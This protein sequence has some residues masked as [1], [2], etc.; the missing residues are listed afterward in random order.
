MLGGFLVGLV[1][2]LPQQRIAVEFFPLLTGWFAG[3]VVGELRFT[4]PVPAKRTVPV[5]AVVQGWLLRVPHVLA[6]I[7]AGVTALVLTLVGTGEPSAQVL[8]WCS[9]ALACAAV[10]AAINRYVLHRVGGD[11]EVDILAASRAIAAH[12][13]GA[14][15]AAGSALVVWCLTHQLT[16]LADHAFDAAAIAAHGI[17][18]LWTIGALVIARLLVTATSPGEPVDSAEDRQP[19]VPVLLVVAVL[20]AVSAGWAGYAYWQDHPPYPARAVQAT[21]TVRFTT[22]S[23]FEQDANAMGLAGLTTTVGAPHRRPFIGRVDHTVPAGADNHDT[24]YVIVIDKRH[25]R[26]AGDLHDNTGGGWS[27][28]LSNLAKRYPWLSSTAPTI[29]AAGY[30]YQGSAVSATADSPDPITFAG[31]LDHAEHLSPADLT[32]VLILTGP[33]TKST[34]P[35]PY[36]A[37]THRQASAHTHG[38]TGRRIARSEAPQWSRPCLTSRAVSPLATCETRRCLAGNSISY[39]DLTTMRRRWRDHRVLQPPYAAAGISRGRR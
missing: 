11:A 6:A 28:S 34:G 13:V 17:G 3:A 39:C 7:T 24:Y 21:A 2:A 5:G 27:S 22:D 37:D 16:V 20:A 15:T 1:A 26:L 9:G 18:L 31:S 10:T 30:S 29:N 33:T 19:L 25:N 12:A 14:I 38:R 4:R 32:V 23:R 8:R 35:P 36:P